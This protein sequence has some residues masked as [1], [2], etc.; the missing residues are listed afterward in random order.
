MSWVSEGEVDDYDTNNRN[1][2]DDNSGMNKNDMTTGVYKWSRVD[3]E[4]EINKIMT[5]GAHKGSEGNDYS[6][7]NKDN[8]TKYNKPKYD[9]SK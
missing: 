8:D 1:K 9:T 4:S 2:V 5:T 7:I 3:D 6:R